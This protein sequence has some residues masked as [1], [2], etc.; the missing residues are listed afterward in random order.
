MLR[1][2]SMLWVDAQHCVYAMGGRSALYLQYAVGVHSALYLCC[3][4]TLEE[5][6]QDWVYALSRR[7]GL[8]FF[9]LI[10]AW[11][12][13]WAPRTGSML[14]VDAL[15][16]GNPADCRQRLGLFLGLGVRPI[17]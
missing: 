17:L 4:W 12:W 16:S 1:T 5:D 8:G 6:A 15:D 10:D 9:L 7:S 11:D 2:V 3:G 13:V 14:W